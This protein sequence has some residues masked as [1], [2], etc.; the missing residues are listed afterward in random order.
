MHIHWKK[1]HYLL[2][3]L[4]GITSGLRS[5]ISACSAQW[6]VRPLS[7]WVLHWWQANGSTA[8]EAFPFTLPSPTT[9]LDRSQ[10]SFFKS[11]AW[12]GQDS[13]P[14]YQHPSRALSLTD[15]YITP[16]LIKKQRSF[17]KNNFKISF[18]HK[19][20]SFHYKWGNSCGIVS[21]CIIWHHLQI[22]ATPNV[23][24]RKV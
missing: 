21:A 22:I 2:H 13:N 1:F 16:T 4:W 8:R 15:F 10:V 24:K 14:A 3:S 20:L 19:I 11:A 6:A 12:I 18:S 9:R 5:P 7:Q 17:S 23:L